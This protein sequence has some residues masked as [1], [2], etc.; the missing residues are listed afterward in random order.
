[1]R[2][3]DYENQLVGKKCIKCGALIEPF[4]G[5]TFG[6]DGI[7]VEDFLEPVKLFVPC[8]NCKYENTLED[9]KIVARNRKQV[10]LAAPKEVFELKLDAKIDRDIEDKT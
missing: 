1:M 3:G 10:T 6:A 8:T 7:T 2:I 9:L 4:L 5:R